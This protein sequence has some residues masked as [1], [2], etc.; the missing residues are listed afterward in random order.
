MWGNPSIYEGHFGVQF[1]NIQNSNIYLQLERF[2]N[3]LI[4]FAEII[5]FTTFVLIYDNLCCYHSYTRCTVLF[6][7]RLCWFSSS[8]SI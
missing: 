8:S 5:I 6:V 1:V 3:V 7:F 2:T 4:L